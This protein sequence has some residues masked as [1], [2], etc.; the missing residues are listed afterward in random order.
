M[1][2]KDWK[3]GSIKIVILGEGLANHFTAKFVRV[4]LVQIES[5]KV[6]QLTAE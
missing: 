5:R 2:Y 4:K 1:T 3:P 6:G